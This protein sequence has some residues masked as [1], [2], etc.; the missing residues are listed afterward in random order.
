[1]YSYERCSAESIFS[2]EVLSL[3]G[4]LVLE[5]GTVYEG[6]GIGATGT[7]SGEVVF[8]TG[9]TGYQEILTDPS[10]CGQIV[11]MT[12]PLIGNYGINAKDFQSSSPKVRGFV[13]REWCAEPS[14]WQ[15]TGGIEDYLWAEG[16][17]G[18]AGIDTRALTRRLREHGTLRGVV[19][20]GEAA[21]RTTEEL[22]AL[23]GGVAMTGLVEEVTTH[24]PYRI[25]GT[26]PR[27]TVV[28]LGIKQSILKYLIAC[29]FDITVVPAD[30]DAE[31]I[32]RT[33][34]DGVL[35]SNGP[36]DPREL[37]SIIETVGELL[38]VRPMFGICLGH[39][40]LGLALGGD[41]FKLSY[42]HRGA[43]HPVKDL[44]NDRVY[45]TS[46]NH[47]YA[48]DEASLD[49]EQVEITHRNLHDDTVEGLQHKHLPVL[50]VQF[51]PE[52]APGPRDSRHLFRQLQLF[53][54]P[55]GSKFESCRKIM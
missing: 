50:S 36:G 55:D 3:D 44:R 53:M 2:L 17:A 22:A 46:Q 19:A 40:V 38:G 51:H 24:K 30:W 47:G 45:I 15:A 49:P 11:V 31:Q 35:L 13:A 41:S 28:D 20:T 43:N 32:M 7:V 37:T 21:K 4:V 6:Q 25:F 26:G 18:L 5:D 54:A 23:A 16:I 10:Y 12:Y 27:V 29:D 48:V 1:M 14:H 34:P 39:Q 9:M 33:R 8:N 52:A 42:G